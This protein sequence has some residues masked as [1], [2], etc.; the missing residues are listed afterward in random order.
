MLLCEGIFF[1]IGLVIL[2]TGKVKLSGSKIVTGRPARAIGLIFMLDIPFAFVTTALIDASSPNLLN[3]DQGGFESYWID[4]MVVAVCLLIAL[5][6]SFSAPAS[7][8]STMTPEEAARYLRVPPEEIY[9]LIE[10]NRLPAARVGTQYQIAKE[11][12]DAMFRR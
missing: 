12:I 8:P 2:I 7:V 4:I 1:F 3:P 11:Q 9:L 6:V 10:N 5:G